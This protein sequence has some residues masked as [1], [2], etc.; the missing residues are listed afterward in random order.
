MAAVLG[1]CVR[2]SAFLNLLVIRLAMEAIEV[3]VKCINLGDEE[4]EVFFGEQVTILASGVDAI[5]GTDLL[6]LRARIATGVP[7][8]LCLAG[9]P[10]TA[11]WTTFWGHSC[12]SCSWLWL[13]ECKLECVVV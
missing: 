4:V 12:G 7:P 13:A 6:A 5:M 8:R 11:V 1:A 2:L 9:G 3:S 10:M